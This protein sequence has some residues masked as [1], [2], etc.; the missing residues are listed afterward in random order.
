[1][2]I[3]NLKQLGTFVDT[4]TCIGMVEGRLPIDG[5]YFHLSFD[6]GFRNVF[7]N[8]I[9]ILR[10]LQVPAIVFV[11]TTFVN[12]DYEVARRYCLVGY[13]GVIE[14][15]RWDDLRTIVS[16]GYEVGSH[17]RTHA[18]FSD[19]STSGMLEHEIRGSK[20]DLESHLE[21]HCKYIS[22]PYGTRGDADSTSLAMAR[23]AGYR[24]CF[25]AFRGSVIQKVTSPFSIPR[26]HFEAQWPLSHIK[27]FAAGN[28]ED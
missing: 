28:M 2:I 11:P 21:I 27:Y 20:S 5:Q 23:D 10:E 26:H 19:L 17:T 12:A 22:W 24:A 7:R 14:M 1:M 3:K 13:A 9:P 8:A 16:W 15:L 25:G 6:D 18:R 4:D